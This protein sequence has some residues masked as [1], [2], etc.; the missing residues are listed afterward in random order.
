MAPRT[1]VKLRPQPPLLKEM[2][3]KG[4]DFVSI[5]LCLGGTDVLILQSYL[6]TGIGP[7]G[8]NINRVRDI[9]SH[10]LLCNLPFI[11]M[12]DMNATPT[13]FMEYNVLQMLG[14][15]ILAPPDGQATAYSG[16]T[17]DYAIVSHL[18]APACTLDCIQ[19]ER[20]CLY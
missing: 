20:V 15:A 7:R 17:L 2:C 18:M 13:E 10:I 19:S 5:I 3:H 8:N 11:W 6:Q 4:F 9:V 1:G 12:G 14:A 16:R